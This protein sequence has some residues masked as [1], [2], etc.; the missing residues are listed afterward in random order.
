MTEPNV[1]VVRSGPQTLPKAVGIPIVV[2]LIL[3]FIILGFPWDS[4]AR[5]VAWE[6]SASSGSSVSIDNLA[7]ALTPRG[8]VLRARNVVIEH[9]AVDRV[10]LLEL[11]IAPR[12]SS[13]WIHGEPTLRVWADTELG[14]IDGVLGLGNTPSFGG[15]VSRVE[16]A[17]LPLR[18]EA[19]GV[20]VSG[21]LDADVDVALAPNGTLKGRVAFRSPSLVIES[22]QLPMAIPFSRAEGVILILENG[23][24]RIESLAVEGE[25]LEGKLSG[26]IGLVHHSQAPPIDLSA[27]FRI[28][29][30]ILRRLASGTGIPI[31]PNG[32]IAVRVRGT[33]D[34]PE[35]DTLPRGGDTRDVG[36]R[37]R[38]KRDRR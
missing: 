21:R 24:T 23:A 2:V 30:P 29:D 1:S 8:P 32:E 4:L 27:E 31:L 3:A 13:S 11:E 22:N 25:L 5:R 19:S 38:P 36:P 35:I 14:L 6:I 18:L 26:E 17:R 33:L 16:L 10:R 12:W 34:A 37:N 28:V 20:R 9:P 7:P 15:R